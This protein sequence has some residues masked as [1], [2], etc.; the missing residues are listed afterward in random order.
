MA[1]LQLNTDTLDD[2][3]MAKLT[4]N[5]YLISTNNDKGKRRGFSRPLDP[6]VMRF[7]EVTP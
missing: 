3:R 6:L 2:E 4:G 1:W 5:Q 7:L